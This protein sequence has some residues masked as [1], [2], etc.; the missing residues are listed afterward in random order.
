M[1][2]RDIVSA[3]EEAADTFRRAAAAHS[4]ALVASLHRPH[5]TQAAIDLR[6]AAQHK[7]RVFG[8]LERQCESLTK[9]GLG[10]VAVAL[11]DSAR[12]N[13]DLA[14]Q[15]AAVEASHEYPSFAEAA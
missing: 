3:I 10:S 9:H 2:N 5:D 4:R 14:E 8:E 6:L 1:T 12:R 13:A 11:L 7:A 15:L